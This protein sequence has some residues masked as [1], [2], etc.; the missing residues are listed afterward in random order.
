MNAPISKILIVRLSAMGDIVM[1]TPLLAALKAEYPGVKISW[2]VQPEFADVI[3]NH[4][5]IDEIVLV[6]KGQWKKDLK[7]FKWLKVWREI[8]TIKKIAQ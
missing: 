2:M 8:R 1:A 6:P 3:R 4:P 7:A 5:L